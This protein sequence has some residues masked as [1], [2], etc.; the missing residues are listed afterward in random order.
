MKIYLYTFSGISFSSKS[1]KKNNFQRIVYVIC[2]W[3]TNNP[4]SKSS[5]YSFYSLCTRSFSNTLSISRHLY[6]IFTLFLSYFFSFLFCFVNKSIPIDFAYKTI[7]IFLSLSINI[8]LK[9]ISFFNYWRMIII[10]TIVIN[11]IMLCNVNRSLKWFI[12][13]SNK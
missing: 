3:I 4:V 8:Y 2:V 1:C 5:V 10:M 13:Y 11:G 12:N 7:V 9:C 6:K